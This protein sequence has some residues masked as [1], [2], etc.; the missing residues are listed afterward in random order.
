MQ[1][2]GAHVRRPPRQS[3][4]LLSMALLPVLGRV[5]TLYRALGTNNSLCESHHYLNLG[6]WDQGP[7]GGRDHV[8]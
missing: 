2:I 4:T 1:P 8:V 7:I 5:D 6:Y 3:L